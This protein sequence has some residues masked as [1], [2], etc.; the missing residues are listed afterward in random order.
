MIGCWNLVSMFPEYV[1][2]T[3]THA[4]IPGLRREKP[5]REPGDGKAGCA[6]KMFNVFISL[7]NGWVRTVQG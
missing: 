3:W 7:K 2:L 1:V 5:P 4:A 6:A